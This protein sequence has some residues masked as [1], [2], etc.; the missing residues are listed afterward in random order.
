MILERIFGEWPTSKLFGPMYLFRVLVL[1]KAPNKK[2]S[3]EH[4]KL[5]DIFIK[6][7]SES[8]PK[9]VHTMTLTLVKICD[10]CF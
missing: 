9:T 2:L 5:K 3:Q 10:L 6:F 7:L 4:N 1:R 8:A